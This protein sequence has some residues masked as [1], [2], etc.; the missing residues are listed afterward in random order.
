MYTKCQ[1]TAN[2]AWQSDRK[3]PQQKMH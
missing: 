3:I 1:S 2:T